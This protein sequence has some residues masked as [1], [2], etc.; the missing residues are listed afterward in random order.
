VADPRFLQD[1]FDKQLAHVV[2]ECGEV[3]AAAGKTQRW[4]PASVNPLLP[5]AQQETNLAWL[6]RELA[7]LRQ[8][9][10]RLEATIEKDFI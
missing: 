9:M 1:G 6:R 4:G 10:D 7:D 3:L 8:A 2:E 5:P